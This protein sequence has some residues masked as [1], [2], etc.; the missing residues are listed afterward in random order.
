MLGRIFATIVMS[1]A[2]A[3]A[4]V[5]QT[6]PAAPA[7]R[8]SVEQ[9]ASGSSV[10]GAALSPSGRYIAFVR[11][12]TKSNGFDT[13]ELIIVERAT[14][15]PT[16]LAQA[17]EEAGIRLSWVDW[18]SDDRLLL[19]TSN[20]VNV[21]GEIFWTGRVVAMPRAGGASVQLFEGS[22]HRLAVAFAP[23]S[24]ASRLPRDPDHVLLTAYGANGNALWKSNVNTGRV[25]RVATGTWDTLR[26][27]MDVNGA[28]VMRVDAMPRNSGRRY[29]RRGPS[30]SGWTMFYELKKAD[31]VNQTEFNPFAATGNPGEIYVAAR[32]N[33][34]DRAAIFAFNTATGDYGP[35][36]M[37][38]E[39]ADIDMALID[40]AGALQGVCADVERYEYV[41]R[42][43]A[44]SRHIN[45]VSGFFNNEARVEII[46]ASD[47][48]KIW[49]LSVEQP[50]SPP[51][52][53]LFDREALKVDALVS[54]DAALD[55]VA[56][57]RTSVVRY[58]A[59]DGTALWG[60]LTN[61]PAEGAA[62]KA[63]IVMPHG[64]PESRDRSGHN[65]HA[66]FLAS[67]GY[68]VFQPNFRGG[69]GFGR[70]FAEAGH[71][72][73]GRLMQDDVTDGVK[74][75]IHARI[76]D[77]ARICIYGWSYGGYA[78]LAGGAMTPELY[79]CVISGAGVSDL[80]RMLET[81]RVEG[82][83]GSAGYAYWVKAIGD[84]VRDRAALEATS[85]R[86]LA[87]AFRAP[88]LL[89]HG[90]ADSV[91]DIEQSRGMKT[92]LTTAGKAV[93][94]V[95]YRG[96]GHSPFAW[97]YKNRVAY[98]K[99]LDAFLAQHLPPN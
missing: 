33:N 24:I 43:R 53:F 13:D 8:P 71:R 93:T 32:P 94:L 15:A 76:A 74:H 57:S 54:T 58:T 60:Y 18:K 41:G 65:E 97:E 51:G 46:G 50:G 21:R 27:L 82:G 68:A 80:P 81:E 91:V 89:L 87:S 30:E 22:A 34:E 56:L 99:E 39:K 66:Q 9:F 48:F 75:L 63:L 42:E 92:A 78:A 4:A 7:T 67:R 70:A 40:A 11:Q 84:P 16:V 64:G 25:E 45:A 17:R 36:L 52:V 55:G 85:P 79:R 73:W 6:T 1:L 98:M 12:T 69:D 28:P 37:T 26:W 96:E 86:R 95:E 31:A 19:G 10:L 5:G 14:M 35:A 90:D 3:G 77:P 38:H 20:R 88:V 83:R 47:D 72:Q 59:R 62:P 61:G 23:V 49:L 29:F 44:V 2:C